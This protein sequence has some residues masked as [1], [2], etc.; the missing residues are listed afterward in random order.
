M[1]DQR[2]MTVRLEAHSA[3]SALFRFRRLERHCEDD[4]PAKMGFWISESEISSSSLSGPNRTQRIGSPSNMRQ[5]IVTVAQSTCMI[6][7]YATNNPG[8]PVEGKS[9]PGKPEQ[10][11]ELSLGTV[12]GMLR[13]RKSTEDGQAV[14]R[15]GRVLVLTCPEGV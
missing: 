11:S 5:V 8:Q 3:E 4:M 15:S 13:R 6:I 2:P 10:R 1:I 7:P 9:I 12:N 14:Y